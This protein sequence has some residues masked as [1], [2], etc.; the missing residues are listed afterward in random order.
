MIKI[1]ENLRKIPNLIYED[2][3]GTHMLTGYVIS[4]LSVLDKLVNCVDYL[5]M[6]FLQI[7]PGK[8]QAIIELYMSAINDLKDNKYDPEKYVNLMLTILPDTLISAGFL[9]GPKDI[10]HLLKDENE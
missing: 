10:L 8:V 3:Q 7:E 9:G 2:K 6:N 5:A 4:V 1:K